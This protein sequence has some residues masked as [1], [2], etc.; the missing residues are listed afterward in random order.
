M[1]DAILYM[2]IAAENHLGNG[3]VISDN[4]P[5]ERLRGIAGLHSVGTKATL[6]ILSYLTKISAKLQ[7]KP[8]ADHRSR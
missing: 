2:Y 3:I 4:G 5:T 6:E 1:S 8:K 7:Q